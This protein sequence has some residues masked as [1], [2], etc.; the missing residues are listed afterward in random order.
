M[1]KYMLVVLIFILSA[2]SSGQKRASQPVTA[3]TPAPTVASAFSTT[4]SSGKRG[5]KSAPTNVPAP[6]NASAQLPVS[7][8][9]APASLQTGV[10]KPLG[11]YAVVRVEE[12]DY[13]LAPDGVFVDLF[14]KSSITWQQAGQPFTLRMDTAFPFD[15][16]V[17]L[18]ISTPKPVHAKLRVRI[19]SW[20]SHDVDVRVNDAA[21]VTGKPGSYVLLDRT[22]AD[23]DYVRFTL[24]MDFRLT[25][26]TGSERVAGQ[27]RYAVEYGP[28]LLALIGAGPGQVDQKG[29]ASVPLASGDLVTRLRPKSGAP[30]HFTIAGDPRHEFI[31][32]W[33]VQDQ[34]FTCYPV[35]S[36]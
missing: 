5:A 20:A 29:N 21:S 25:R 12:Y 35:L 24:P 28:I 30:L 34:L 3:P 15:P 2:C 31:P 13:S 19:P 33:Q 6:T 23:R 27:E 32:Y 10:R 4:S 26:Y 9:N 36:A 22:W 7:T 16:H 18:Q 1:R 11:I 14:E 8:A 17:A